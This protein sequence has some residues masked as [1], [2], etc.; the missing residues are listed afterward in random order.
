M[1]KQIIYLLIMPLFLSCGTGEPMDDTQIDYITKNIS[2]HNVQLIIFYKNS[3][4]IY[5]DT[6]FSIP[7]DNEIKLSYINIIV[8]SPFGLPND[9]A[10]IIFD[11]IK[12]IIYVR[13]DGQARNIL[14][15]NSYEGGKVTEYS[16]KYQYEITDEDY[17]NAVEI[18]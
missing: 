3:N 6:V 10:Y 12:Q 18:K 14:D 7:S 17:A 5:K 11:N 4:N 2:S 8:D 16:Y 1:K 15:I 9:S 13:D